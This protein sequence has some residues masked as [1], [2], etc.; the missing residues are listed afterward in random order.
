LVVHGR[1]HTYVHRL[2]APRHQKGVLGG[3]GGGGHQPS[4]VRFF[5]QHVEE[6]LCR[7]FQNGVDLLQVCRIAVVVEVFPEVGAEPGPSGVGSPPGGVFPGSRE[8]PHVGHHVRH[9]APGIVKG[10]GG[11]SSRLHQSFGEFNEGSVQFGQVGDFRRPVVHLDVDIEVV[12][13]VPG[14]VDGV[15]PEP[16]EVGGQQPRMGAADEQVPPVLEI[17]GCQSVVIGIGGKGLQPLRSGKGFPFGVRGQHHLGPVKPGF[18]GC[19]VF[20]DD[21]FVWAGHRLGQF[22]FNRLFKS[23]IFVVG[24][25]RYVN[26][27]FRGSGND[28][29]VPVGGHFSFFGFYRHQGPVAHALAVGSV[30]QLAGHL[31]PAAG[32]RRRELL[33]PVQADAHVDHSFSAGRQPDEAHIIGKAHEIVTPVTGFPEGIPGGG[34]GVVKGERPVV[35]HGICRGIPLIMEA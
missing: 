22:L 6:E 13:S 25:C 7:S 30:F 9:P 32:C 23:G 2:T 27:G 16:L 31:E 11:L 10:G 1:P 20:P 35:I 24:A 26:E 28:Q 34:H 8:S 18:V 15:G 5:H 17:E 19:N 21:A 3:G 4:V 29:A 12:I 33:R 14:G